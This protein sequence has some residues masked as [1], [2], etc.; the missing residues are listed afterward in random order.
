VDGSAPAEVILDCN[1]L[2]AL[3]E[4]GSVGTIKMSP[5]Q[6]L[7]AYTV[8]AGGDERFS[9]WVKDLDQGRILHADTLPSVGSVEWSADGSCLVYTVPEEDGRPSRVMRH[10]IGFPVAQDECLFHE[11]DPAAYV[12]ISRTKDWAFLVINVNSKAFSEVH[13]LSADTA[14]KPRL[15]SPRKAG[16]QYFVEHSHGHLAILANRGSPDYDLVSVPFAADDISAGAWTS[17][18]HRREDLILEDMDVFHTCAVLYCRRHGMPEV[19]VLTMPP[20]PAQDLKKLC[21][22]P[23]A[24]SLEPGVNPDPASTELL[25]C[26]SSPIHPHHWLRFDLSNPTGVPD[27]LRV[28]GRCQCAEFCCAGEPQP[29][30]DVDNPSPP[31][32]GSAAG[33]QLDPGNSGNEACTWENGAGSGLQCSRILVDTS[34]NHSGSCRLPVTV[35]HRQDLALDGTA[36][37]LMSMYGA[38]GISMET[39]FCSHRLPLLERGWVIA[40]AHCRGGGELGQAWHQD[41]SKLNKPRSL[42]DACAAL[43]HL[44]DAGYSSPGKVAIHAFSAGGLLLGHLVNSRAGVLAA[45]WAQSPFVDLLTAMTSPQLPLTVHEYDEWGD[46]SQPEAFHTI[47]SVCPYQNT[48]SS[49][50]LVADKP[51]FKDRPKGDSSGS[52]PAVF[53]TAAMDDN[54]VPF[55]GPAKWAARLRRAAATG[56]GGGGPVLLCCSEIGGHFGHEVNPVA[57]TARGYAFLIAAVQAKQRSETTS[58]PEPPPS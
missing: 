8:D 44:L 26:A 20:S 58:G 4:F 56:S 9:C 46:P 32:V 23:W 16:H 31:A 48:A 47:A 39:D 10:W 13:L 51:P 6:G 21:L 5:C 49:S 27:L 36:P 33:H 50:P 57:D 28:D 53:I 12:D 15:V 22:P 55:W 42:A 45:A 11:W 52:V 2:E 7:L 29:S 14:Q 3:H 24:L 18:F 40:L 38:Y 41:G 35:M 54:R 19:A 34:D 37:L 17:L 30:G 1:Q 43:D 25:L